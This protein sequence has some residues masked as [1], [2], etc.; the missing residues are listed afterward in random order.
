MMM[1]IHR[2]ELIITL[3]LLL[4]EDTEGVDDDC[5]FCVCEK[6]RGNQSETESGAAFFVWELFKVFENFV[7]S[8]IS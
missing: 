7:C 4:R 8:Q 6:W 2:D 1:M 3:L 5:I